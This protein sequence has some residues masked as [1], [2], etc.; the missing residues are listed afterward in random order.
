MKIILSL[1][2]MDQ[3][4]EALRRHECFNVKEDR[5]RDSKI[6]WNLED[7][8]RYWTGLEFKSQYIDSIKAGYMMFDGYVEPRTQGW[9]KLTEKGAKIVLAWHNMGYKCSGNGYELNEILPMIIEI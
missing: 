6:G 3:L 7:L 4:R 9:L 1:R 8:Q 5:N 2:E